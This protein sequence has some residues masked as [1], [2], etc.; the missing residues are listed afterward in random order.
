[1]K[2]RMAVRTYSTGQII[3]PIVKGQAICLDCLTVEDGTD[4]L[5]RNVGME[6]SFYGA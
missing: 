2:R 1:M 5:S 3:G 4:R 6:L